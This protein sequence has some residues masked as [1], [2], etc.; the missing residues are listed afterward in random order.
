MAKLSISLSNDTLI[1]L[2][3]E[4][5]DLVHEVLGSVLQVVQRTP[6]LPVP[7]A[8]APFIDPWTETDLSRTAQHSVELHSTAHDHVSGNGVEPSAMYRDRPERATILQS[9]HEYVPSPGSRGA[10]GD[11]RLEL[12]TYSSEARDDFVAFCQSINPTGDMRRVVV[13]AE[14]A[15]R[16]FGLD[17]VHADE[18]GELFDLIGWRRANSFTQTIRNAARA[19]FGWLERIPGRSGRY[20][21]TEVGRSTTLSG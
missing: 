5:P 18:V 16:F 17:G 20:A 14:A 10:N 9:T 8:D 3:C 11:D 2:E 15:N 1:T 6:H 19:K 7:V 21:A 12:G 13:A 4:E